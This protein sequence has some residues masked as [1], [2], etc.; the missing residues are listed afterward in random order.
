MNP[1]KRLFSR[2]TGILR[3]L[4]I[5]YIINNILNYRRLAHNRKMLDELGLDRN[6]V[7]PV[8][9]H[10]LPESDDLPWLDRPGALEDMKS[11]SGWSSFSPDIQEELV[12]FVED[13]FM[14]LKGYFSEDE[15]ARHN[16]EVDRLKEEGKIDF[17]YSGSKLMNVHEESPWISERFYKNERLLEIL[18]F[19]F[20]RPVLP[21]QTIS[22][23]R[24]SQQKA[25]SDS[26]HMS[27]YPPGY[28]LGVWTALEDIE[29]EQGPVFYYPG[30]HRLPYVS[31]EDY[32]S[33]NTEWTIGKNSYRNYEMYVK[34][35]LESEGLQPSF[36]TAQ[37]GDVLIW[38][39]NLLHGGS[40]ILNENATRRSMVA[41]YYADGVFCYHEIS[42]RPALIRAD[43]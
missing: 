34:A 30:S 24:G 10:D 41:H 16:A 9:M 43:K 13:G 7:L 22:F 38:H 28:L 37:A 8:G 25:H 2:Y 15:V 19:I 31:T 20:G 40:G 23:I 33:G 18:E 26:I 42:Q 21:F 39:A 35:L 29:I 5:S 12:R 4:K 1:I 11:H 27:T 14:V 36:F 17:N 6:V 32:E 3:S